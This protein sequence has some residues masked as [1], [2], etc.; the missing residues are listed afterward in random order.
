MN[1][2][3]SIGAIAIEAQ[4]LSVCLVIGRLL[5]RALAYQQ[6]KIIK[7]F[8]AVI[9]D[10]FFSKAATHNHN[11]NTKGTALFSQQTIQ[12]CFTLKL[13][14]VYHSPK[15]QQFIFCIM[16]GTFVGDLYINHNVCNPYESYCTVSTGYPGL[17]S[18]VIFV[19]VWLTGYMDSCNFTMLLQK[20][21]LKDN[22]HFNN[23]W[24]FPLNPSRSPVTYWLKINLLSITDC[25]IMF[26]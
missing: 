10:I 20:G 2:N 21:R 1:T 7:T 25:Y 14:I 18:D 24:K 22:F 13:I 19:R 5:V 15:I 12:S 9:I 3:T 8:S 17:S 16:S 23:S 4:Q 11:L 6:K 26:V